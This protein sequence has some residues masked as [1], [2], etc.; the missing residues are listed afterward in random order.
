[1]AVKRQRQRG[2]LKSR[3]LQFEC[4][5]LVLPL[6]DGLFHEFD[7]ITKGR[8]LRVFIKELRSCVRFHQYRL[9]YSSNNFTCFSEKNTPFFISRGRILFYF[10]LFYFKFCL[11]SLLQQRELRLHNL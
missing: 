4:R 8:L 9:L 2:P 5:K 7:A 11:Q 6:F 10:F 1:M 3:V